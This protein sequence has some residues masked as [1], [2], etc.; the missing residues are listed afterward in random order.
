MVLRQLSA[1]PDFRRSREVIVLEDGTRTT[2]AERC[3][4]SSEARPELRGQRRLFWGGTIRHIGI[5]PG[6]FFLN[7]GRDAAPTVVVRDEQMA[8]LLSRKRLAE[9]D[10]LAGAAFILHG[11]LGFKNHRLWL[12][13][14]DLDWFTV[15][16]LT[17][18]ADF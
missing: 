2:V 3:V 9:A 13:A 1:D 17:E 8:R 11:R 10:D 15:L 4:H 16:P 14:D 12:H 18:A 5:R 6:V 7:T